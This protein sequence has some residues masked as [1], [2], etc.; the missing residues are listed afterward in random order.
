MN[1]LSS[2]DERNLE[3]DNQEK[4]FLIRTKKYGLKELTTNLTEKKKLVDKLKKILSKKY[5]LEEM[6]YIILIDK[7]KLDNKSITKNSI[8]E[9]I[10]HLN[11]ELRYNAD[12][13]VEKNLETRTI[14]KTLFDNSLNMNDSMTVFNKGGPVKNDIKS[15]Y[16]PPNTQT[17]II[18]DLLNNFD[19]MNFEGLYN[20]PIKYTNTKNPIKITITDIILSGNIITKY[21]LHTR[22]YILMKI[23]EFNNNIFMNDSQKQ[24]FTYFNV[25]NTSTSIIPLLNKNS[26][27][28]INGSILSNLTISFYD[29]EETLIKIIDFN[30]K[31]DFFKIILNLEF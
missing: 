14:E 15:A 1:Q 18:L 6:D 25:D 16:A 11:M 30:E 7:F 27:I 31:E 10:S 26:Y 5:K 17:T 9:L 4:E 3:K 24:Y 12:G 2:R 22:P 8:E 29:H 13:S 21:N 28:P 23:R 19:L 20:V